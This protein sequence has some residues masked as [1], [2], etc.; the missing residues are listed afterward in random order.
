ML[1]TRGAMQI[2]CYARI[3]RHTSIILNV[4]SSDTIDMVKSKIHDRWGMCP[5]NQQLYSGHHVRYGGVRM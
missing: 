1:R 2:F 5:E 4:E 3:D